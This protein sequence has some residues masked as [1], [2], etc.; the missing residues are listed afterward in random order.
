[1][2]GLIALLTSQ[3]KDTCAYFFA[4]ALLWIIIEYPCDRRGMHSC[5]AGKVFQGHHDAT[6]P[7][8]WPRRSLTDP[9]LPFALNKR[10]F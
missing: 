9:F 4:H 7:L 1:M 10:L 8:L 5:Q 2:I 3:R 6:S